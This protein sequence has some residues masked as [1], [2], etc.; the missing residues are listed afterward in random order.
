MGLL[1]VAEAVRRC[2]LVPAQ[3]L[4]GVSPDMKRKGRVQVG[5]DA[6]IVVFDAQSIADRATYASPVETSIGISHVIVNGVFVV[7][8]GSLEPSARPGRAIKGAATL[9]G[10]R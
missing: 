1:D 9:A 8:E 2:T 6:D 4:E 10:A 7:R 3:I 5:A